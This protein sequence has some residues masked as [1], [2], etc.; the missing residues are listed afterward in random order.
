MKNYNWSAKLKTNKALKKWIRMK[1]RNQNNKDWNSKT[2]NRKDNH[3][4]FHTGKR[5]EK[6]P[7][8]INCPSSTVIRHTRRKMTW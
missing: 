1:I 4:H 7:P 8:M 5:G 3:V 6:G 2:K